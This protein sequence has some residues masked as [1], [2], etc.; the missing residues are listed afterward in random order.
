M[1]DAERPSVAASALPVDLEGRK[2]DLP[3]TKKHLSPTGGRKQL[4]VA[5]STTRLTPDA[6][7]ASST[8]P[9]Q[10]STTA[11]E[12]KDKGGEEQIKLPGYGDSLQ[13]KQP[14]AGLPSSTGPPNPR[15]LI[16]KLTSHRSIPH[17]VFV[18]PRTSTLLSIW[19]HD[20]A[21]LSS[22][23]DPLLPEIGPNLMPREDG[24]ESLWTEAERPGGGKLEKLTHN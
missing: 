18:S 24:P 3:V 12:S 17:S 8:A 16:Q 21:T 5:V 15:A 20:G 7:S 23:P 9:P 13:D 4:D 10:L 14:E 2:E 1:G 19:G 11:R 6:F 22:L